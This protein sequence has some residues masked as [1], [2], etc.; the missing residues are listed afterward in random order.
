MYINKFN[1][2]NRKGKIRNQISKITHCFAEKYLFFLI[3]Y[4]EVN[5]EAAL[6][7]QRKW[8]PELELEILS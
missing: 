1:Q 4:L 6:K 7:T 5:R 3:N 2:L 8:S